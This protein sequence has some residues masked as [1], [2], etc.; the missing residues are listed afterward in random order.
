MA[1]RWHASGQALSSYWIANLRAGPGRPKTIGAVKAAP[2]FH[3]TYTGA[4]VG[5]ADPEHPRGAGCR[6]WEL[7]GCCAT[8]V[9]AVQVL[10]AFTVQPVCL[11]RLLA[12][13]AN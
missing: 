2:R 6:L 13:L 1:C 3:L 9:A 4:T 10:H 5:R 12:E 8:Y 11:G 7:P